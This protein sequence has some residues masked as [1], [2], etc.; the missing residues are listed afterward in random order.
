MVST[1]GGPRASLGYR[2]RSRHWSMIVLL[3]ACLLASACGGGVAEPTYVPRDAA[4]RALPLY[5]YPV[6]DG[7]KARA[8]VFLFGND[9][10]FWKPHRELAAAMARQGYDV[11]G[12]DLKPLFA[13][14]PP[15]PAARQ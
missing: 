6:A 4:L 9:V 5:F 2:R 3:P 15:D 14:L 10:G 1:A 8:F 11:V 12:C 13:T 7:G